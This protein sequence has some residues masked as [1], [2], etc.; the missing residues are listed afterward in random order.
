MVLFLAGLQDI[1]RDYYEASSIDGANGINQ[2][3]NIT[4]PLLSSAVDNLDLQLKQEQ[5]EEALKIVQTYEADANYDAEKLAQV[6]AFLG[7]NDMGA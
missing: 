3:F 1:P 4:I 7:L 2:F 5:K 6:K